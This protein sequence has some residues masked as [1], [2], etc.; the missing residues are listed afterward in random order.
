MRNLGGNVEV[1][2]ILG[3]L[4]T[5]GGNVAVRGNV[6]S[7]SGGGPVSYKKGAVIGGIPLEKAVR[8]GGKQ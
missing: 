5:S 4:Y 2:G 3:S 8:K 1:E 7:V 6:G